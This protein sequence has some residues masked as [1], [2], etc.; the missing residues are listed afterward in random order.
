M[1]E[2]QNAKQALSEEVQELKMKLQKKHEE[3]GNLEVT[4]QRLVKRV[5]TLQGEKEKSA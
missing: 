1:R 5:E 3:F 4:N 2:D